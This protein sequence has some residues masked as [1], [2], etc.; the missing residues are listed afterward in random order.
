MKCPLYHCHLHHGPVELLDKY[1]WLPKCLAKV[2]NEDD[3]DEDHDPQPGGISHR[4]YV[5][6]SSEVIYTN[7]FHIL[8][9]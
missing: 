8:K 5:V 1:D 6:P 2:H 9:G 7:H 4:T 3:E